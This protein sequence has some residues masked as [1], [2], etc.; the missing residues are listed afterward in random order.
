[1]FQGLQKYGGYYYYFDE[2]NGFRYEDGFLKVNGNTY[3]FNKNGRAQV[4]S[5]VIGN[6]E[7][8]FATNGVLKSTTTVV[9]TVETTAPTSART[10]KNYLANALLPVGKT[11]YIYGGGH[12]TTDATRK[13]VSPNWAKWYSKNNSSYNYQNYMYQS[14]LG[15]DC[16]GY[17]G[18]S[19]YQVMQSRSNVGSGYTVTS[20]MIG[21]TYTGYKW[22][23]NL[24]QSYLQS[25]NF[26]FYPGDIGYDGDHTWIVLGQCKDTSLV[27][28]HST[29]NAGVQ[30]A[31]TPTYN[32][33]Y[34]SQAI[35]LAKQYMSRYKGYQ[36]MGSSF[37]HTSTG[38]W[39]RRG[40]YF[41]WN[42]S[43]LSDPDGY[44]SMT[45]DQILAD[46]FK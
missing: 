36:T 24:T 32:G 43:T 39:I 3:Y 5:L 41:R 21:S 9:E 8:T 6:K 35:S 40:N 31:G 17:V 34:S 23:T 29:P 45:A 42:R 1:M 33:N 11:L 15:L 28:L 27:I 18:W 37:Y 26:K 19:V 22:G 14:T 10:I 20:G 13:G 7:Y 44:L 12:N 16:S 38:H 25:H 46:L 2:N 4:G 30:I